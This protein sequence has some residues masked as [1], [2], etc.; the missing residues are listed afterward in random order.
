MQAGP[1]DERSALGAALA[2]LDSPEAALRAKGCL[3]VALLVRGSPHALAAAC[4]GALP[5]ASAAAASCKR[6]VCRHEV[7]TDAVTGHCM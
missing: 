1:H 3:L 5:A 2:L 7:S 4:N 6:L